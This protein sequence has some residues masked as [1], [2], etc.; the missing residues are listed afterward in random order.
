MKMKTLAVVLTI[1]FT[2]A[3]SFG[4]TILS[5]KDCID[6]AYKYNPEIRSA[7]LQA[8][9]GKI[10]WKSS[11]YS[12]LPSLS[13]GANHGYNFGRSIDRF[14]NQFM[15]KRILSDYFSLNADW[16][17]YNGL[18]KQNTIRLQKFNYQASLKDLE[19][20]KNQ[21]ALNVASAYLSLLMAKE[22]VRSME[23]Q[24]SSTK[25]QLERTRKLVESGASDKSAELTL[26]SQLANESLSLVEAQNQ[27][28]IAKVNLLNLIL[29]PPSENWDIE[30][31]QITPNP[32]TPVFATEQVYNNALKHLPEIESSTLKVYSS[33]VSE[34]INKGMQAPVL[35]LYA[36]MSTVFSQNAVQITNM[37]PVGTQPIGYVSNT[38]EPVLQP[39]FRAETKVIPLGEQLNNNFGQ[40]IGISFSW[41][42]FNG[43]YVQHNIQ[44]S[45]INKQL[46][47]NNLQQTK[48]VLKANVTKAIA[49][50]NASVSKK[51]ASE[52][53][54]EAA[55]LQMEYAQKR[56]ENGLLN[57]YDYANAK[58][59]L[60]KAEISALQ[61]RYELLFNRMVVEFY[62]G[63]AVEIR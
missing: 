17:I 10:D 54:L 8:Q 2:A 60:L 39:T 40:T 29:I 9:I 28:E 35:S 57:P 11:Q 15:T 33:E 25:E 61:A 44:K 38:L 45:S 26:E 36:N 43:M 14:S 19:S 22:L 7:Q 20:Y 18:Q 27:R 59:Q 6:L 24:V 48:N 46:Q 31:P 49:D 55:R 16:V 1:Y 58:N 12:M 37:I 5:L 51:N 21:L 23:S 47:Q 42:I 30:E 53:A 4:Q 63:S 32:E 56:F 52:K 41:N 62:N 13:F 34:K 50:Y 3:S